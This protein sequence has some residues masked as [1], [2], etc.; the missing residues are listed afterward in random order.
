LKNRVKKNYD[1]KYKDV[2]QDKMKYFNALQRKATKHLPDLNTLSLKADGKKP[3]KG[4]IIHPLCRFSRRWTPFDTSIENVAQ[5][6]GKFDPESSSKW[7]P[8]HSISVWKKM[9]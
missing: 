5:T 8:T 3:A 7:I 4:S 6:Y 9:A 1:E 2:R